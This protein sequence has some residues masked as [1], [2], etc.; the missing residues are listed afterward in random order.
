[1][2][3]LI[4]NSNG[5]YELVE[6][7][8]PSAKDDTAV[9]KV[10]ATSICGTDFR[11]YL[12]GSSKI[13]PGT[14]VGHEMCGEIVDIGKNV[15]GFKLGERVTVAPALGCGECYM[16]KKGSTNMCDNLKTLGFQYDGSFAEYMEIPAEFFTRGSVNPVADNVTA[17]QAALAEPV[18][19]AVNAQEYLAIEKGDY[20]AVFGSGF[21][22]TNHADIAFA[23]G[24]EKVI[25]IEPNAERLAIAKQFV[26]G[27]DTI[28]G[29]EDV[30]SRV[31]EITGGRGVDVAIVAC[32]VG[33]AQVTAQQIIAKRGRISL[34]GGLPGNGVGFIDSNVIHYKE[35]GVFGAHASTAAQNKKVLSWLADGKIETAKYVTHTYHLKDAMQAFD[36]IEK[37]GIMKAVIV[38][39][40]QEVK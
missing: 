16:C 19:C 35:V 6:K 22:G 14:T 5:K 1:M 11:T 28:S 20:V 4:F 8:K 25:M 33:A 37:K 17:L 9:I 38:S 29:S 10:L 2:Q 24:A 12:H 27:I 7:P 26:P 39:D 40:D 21:I 32:S 13:L 36:D 18:A 30:V 34:F 3:A 31:M 15:N 23:S